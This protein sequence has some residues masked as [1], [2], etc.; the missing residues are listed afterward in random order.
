MLPKKPT[1]DRSADKENVSHVRDQVAEREA[2]ICMADSV[3]KLLRK[4]TLLLES[5][6]EYNDDVQD[7]RD[8]RYLWLR[9]NCKKVDACLNT[10]LRYVDMFYGS[11][12]LP[13]Q[14]VHL[15]SSPLRIAIL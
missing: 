6:E 8:E 12:F 9:D 7:S 1:L 14:Y 4:K 15:A 5:L 11:A 13:N 3:D 10:L 2:L